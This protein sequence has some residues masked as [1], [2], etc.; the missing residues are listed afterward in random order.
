MLDNKIFAQFVFW[1]VWLI[2]PLICELAIGFISAIICIV[3]FAN[4]QSKTNLI[5]KTDVS[6]LIPVYNSQDTLKKCLESI[7]NQSYP[8]ENIEVILIDNGSKDNSYKIFADFQNQ[9]IN[10]KS[11][12]IS[13]GQGKAKALNKGIFC[14]TA[15]Y[16]INIDSDGWLHK[17]AV[18]NVIRKFEKNSDICCMTGVV[19]VENDLIEQTENKILKLL[20][21]CE[22][23]EYIE[24]FLV[25]RNFYSKFNSMYTLAGA[26]SCFRREV[27]LKTSMYNFSTVGEDT[28]MTF[29]V[30]NIFEKN[31]RLC[32]DAFFYV[33][34]I[35]DLDKLYTLRQRWQRGQIEVASLYK[36]YHIGNILNFIKNPFMRIIITDHTLVFPR[37]IWFFGMIYLY[38]I[39]YPLGLLIS[40]N[41]L[42]YIAYVIN[43]FLYLS[44]GKL[45]LKN[46]KEDKQYLSKYWYMCFFI[47]I[48]R[49]LLYWIRIAGIINSATKQANWKVQNIT[50][51]RVMIKNIIRRIL[52]RFYPIW[53]YI[54]EILND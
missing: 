15:R 18:K 13:S 50:E 4:S 29:Q 2:I 38:Y 6:I 36:N 37:L 47:P 17:D 9:N 30:R 35:E 23:L 49:F 41:L 54:Y 28:H 21:R 42:I 3:S 33:D 5:Y 20:R 25:G 1:A 51:E 8:T 32:E 27:L 12:W 40:S 53:N 31:I 14:S 48:Y 19:L 52:N 44:V 46:Q 26:F 43:S 24:S 10:I 22:Y 39:N 45:Y 11:W 34:P 16:V 7:L